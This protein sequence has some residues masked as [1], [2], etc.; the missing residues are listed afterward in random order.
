MKINYE[1]QENQ[2]INF[3]SP[4]ISAFLTASGGLLKRK[5]KLFFLLCFFMP[6]VVFSYEFPPER[7]ESDAENE[8]GWLVAPLPIV[9]EGIGTGFPI[10]ASISN[11]FKKT[12][13]LMA[14]TLF[15]GDFEVSLFSLS[16]YPVVDEKLLFS[17]GFT[18]FYMPFRSYDRGIDSGKEDYYQTLEKFNS[19]FVTL[20]SQLYNQ[21]LE[22]L[23][24]YS[25]GGTKLEKIFDVDGN[26]FSN[27]QSPERS[28]IDH[29]IGT[30][31]DLTDNHLDPSEGLRIGLLHSKTNYEHN[32][33]S[34]YAVNDLNITAYF[35]FFETHTLLFN[36]FQSRSNITANGLVDETAVRNKFGLGCDLEKETAAC[37]KTETR[38][39]NYWLKR[40]QSSKATALGGLNRM[41]AYSQGRFYAANSS[42]YVLEYRLNYSEKRTPMNWIVLGGIRTVL[43]TSFFY[44]TGSVSDD[45]SRLHKKM[46]SSFGV[47]FRAIISGLIY[48]FDLAKGDDGIAPTLFINYPLSLGTLGS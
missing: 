10:A 45:I 32:D 39:I 37:R 18:D 42:N 15:K 43:Q 26:D 46:K 34:D 1:E 48:R 2:Y 31:I 13:L 27:I 30:Q 29:V 41:R 22:F 35:P 17:L 14:K 7:S 4:M 19:N 9:V 23:L 44:E 6:S 20:Q 24:S 11:I 28:W 12:D 47:G 40:N 25:A 36:A 33:L 8:I 5:T 16:K 21:R 3:C 38:R